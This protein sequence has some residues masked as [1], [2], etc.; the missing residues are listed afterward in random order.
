MTKEE[1]VMTNALLIFLKLRYKHLDLRSLGGYLPANQIAE[2]RRLF[3]GLTS[4][5]FSSSQEYVLQSPKF[6]A[7]ATLSSWVTFL[8]RHVKLLTIVAFT[9]PVLAKRSSTSLWVPWTLLLFKLTEVCRSLGLFTVIWEIIGISPSAFSPIDKEAFATIF[10][11]MYPITNN[12]D[13]ALQ[14]RTVT[15][16]IRSF[17]SL[18]GYEVKISTSIS[19]K[20]GFQDRLNTTLYISKILFDQFH[21]IV[22]VSNVSYLRSRFHLPPRSRHLRATNC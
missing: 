14:V 18:H 22:K 9:A 16:R 11:E 13:S 5:Q 3:L 8:C 20:L 12:H 7:F 15:S 6:A 19:R 4:L 10:T 2:S 17:Q 1:V 21:W